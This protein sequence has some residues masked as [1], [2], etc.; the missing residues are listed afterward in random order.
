MAIELANL[1]LEAKKKMEKAD[2]SVKENRM[3][4]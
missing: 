2:L 1:E 4:R 3:V